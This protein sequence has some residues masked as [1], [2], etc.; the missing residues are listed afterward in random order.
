MSYPQYWDVRRYLLD[1]GKTVLE[2]GGVTIP[3]P[4]LTVHAA[5][6]N[7]AGAMDE[8]TQRAQIGQD[9]PKPLARD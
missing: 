4:Q 6:L 1:E 2:G 9:S 5:G 7:G 8:P 3:F